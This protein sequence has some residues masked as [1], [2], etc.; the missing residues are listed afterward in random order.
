MREVLGRGLE[1]T[2]LDVGQYWISECYSCN[3]FSVFP[4]V[5]KTCKYLKINCLEFFAMRMRIHLSRFSQKKA[6]LYLMLEIKHVI[7]LKCYTKTP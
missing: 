1:Q 2:L 7:R 4:R 3:G 5:Q 6:Q